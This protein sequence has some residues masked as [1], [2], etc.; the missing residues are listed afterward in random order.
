MAAMLKQTLAVVAAA[1]FAHGLYAQEVELKPDHPDRYVV[2]KGDT[3]WDISA[4]FLNSPWLWPEV[5]Q[6]NPQIQN[7]HL[8]YPG[9]VISLV[10]VDGKP[11]L[12][13]SRDPGSSGITGPRVRVSELD[14]AITTIPLSKVQQYLKRP[15]LLDK[16]A[17][18]DAPYVVAIEENRIMGTDSQVAYVRQLDAAVGTR[19]AILA[20]SMVYRDLP[21]KWVW[22]DRRT[23]RADPWDLESFN[24][25]SIGKTLN[26]LWYD[27][28]YS[29]RTE[30]L[31]YEVVEVGTAEVVAAG[32]PATVHVS[33]VE[34]EIK[35][36]YILLPEDPRPFD[37]TFFPHSPGEVPEGMR[38]LALN[39]ALAGAGVSQVIV[40]NRGVED[41]IDNGT[42]VSLH[43]PGERIRDDIKAPRGDIRYTFGLGDDKVTLPEEFTGH[44]M[45]FRSF[46]RIS[47]GLIMDAV[48]PVQ[49]GDVAHQPLD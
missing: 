29:S 12:T 3:L 9:D 42:V 7:P 45:V 47:Y 10:Y 28:A 20:P 30:L 22:D 4:R 14:D 26:Y 41:G 11:M 32:D 37:L 1:L 39:E 36:G 19:F 38:V 5:W 2:V 33:Y 44:A 23:Q 21:K 8:I 15:R 17:I 31:G 25:R 49:V 6:A 16:A 35:K 34:R 27:W 40:L 13:L 46:D 48:K 18:A 43:R 24:K